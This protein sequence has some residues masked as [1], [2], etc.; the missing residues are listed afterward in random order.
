MNKWLELQ[1]EIRKPIS[2]YGITDSLSSLK[3]YVSEGYTALSN[4]NTLNK[5]KRGMARRDRLNKISNLAQMESASLSEIATLFGIPII[6]KMLPEKYLG[7]A[8]GT[9]PYIGSLFNIY[10]ALR[11]GYNAY[12][13][14]SKILKDKQYIKINNI[15]SLSTSS[16]SKYLEQYKDNPD[17]LMEL[18]EVSKAGYT[19]WNQTMDSIA[20][21]LDFGY[22]MIMLVIKALLLIPTSGTGTLAMDAVNMTMSIALMYK[23]N[24]QS[25]Y[26]GRGFQDILSKI[27]KT[28]EEKIKQSSGNAGHSVSQS[29]NK[30]VMPNTDKTTLI[31]AVQVNERVPAQKKQISLED[32][33][34]S[35]KKEKPPMAG[36]AKNIDLEE[37]LS[38]VK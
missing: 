36:G 26:L 9:L 23:A 38:L 17:A 6:G 5:T 27:D 21:F 37:F 12:L 19:F 18:V 22:D 10:Y 30:K 11:S 32:F 34:E 20:N 31:D 15:K 7:K 25:E 2:I 3:G 13:A 24:E 29:V 16:L 14:L 1:K 35:M 8:L 4:I 33:G 28:A